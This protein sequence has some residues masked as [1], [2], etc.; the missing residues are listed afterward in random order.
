MLIYKLIQILFLVYS[1]MLIIRCIASWLPE[2]TQYKWMQFLMFYV[3]PYLNLFRRI[4]PPIGGTID[5]SP[6]LAFFSLRL[7]ETLIL[8]LLF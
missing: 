1:Y 4:I 5:L 7:L 2:L 3:D 6:V 8:K